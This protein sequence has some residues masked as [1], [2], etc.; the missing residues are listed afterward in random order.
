MT[1]RRERLRKAVSRAAGQDAAPPQERCANCGIAI[2]D[3]EER[4][5]SGGGGSLSLDLGPG[6]AFCCDG[7]ADGGPCSC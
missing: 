5:P 1:A 3:E 2:D 6:A 7:C 4:E